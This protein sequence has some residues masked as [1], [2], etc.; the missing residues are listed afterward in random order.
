[1]LKSD[2]EENYDSIGE[3]ITQGSFLPPITAKSTEPEEA[4]ISAAEWGLINAVMYSQDDLAQ[5]RSIVQACPPMEDACDNDIAKYLYNIGE[6][7]LDLKNYSK[8]RLVFNTAITINPNFI[9]AYIRKAETLDWEG[10]YADAMRLLQEA[11]KR[12]P[13][14][15]EIL[16][17]LSEL[18]EDQGDYL[19]I[20][21][22][23]KRRLALNP[24]DSATYL[25]LLQHMFD[26]KMFEEINHFVDQFPFPALN[27]Q[28]N[29]RALNLLVIAYM[30]TGE[31]EKALPIADEAL[32]YN[33]KRIALW[34]MKARMLAK[35]RRREEALQ[36]LRHI[37]ELKPMAKKYASMAQKYAAKY[38]LE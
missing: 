4:A 34:E 15:A 37:C 35:L 1:M 12:F 14:N 2:V 5:V 11:H 21:D 6:K 20:A 9:E 8:S 19:E 38:N 25:L 3:A 18:Y 33:P 30:E 7:L 27:A 36:C 26:H 13:T 28:D 32:Q 24:E 29:F 22:Q 23:Y 31:Y 16:S 17:Y 10:K